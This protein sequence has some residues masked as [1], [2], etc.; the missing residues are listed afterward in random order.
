MTHFKAVQLSNLIICK[1]KTVFLSRILSLFC[2]C[3]FLTLHMFFSNKQPRRIT[4]ELWFLLRSALC[5]PGWDLLCG[6]EQALLPHPLSLPSPALQPPASPHSHSLE[7][8]CFVCVSASESSFAS[9][10]MKR[11]KQSKTNELCE[12]S[13]R[14]LNNRL[15]NGA[16]IASLM[17]VFI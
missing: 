17:G 11:K 9:V 6:T 14:L 8:F 7:P 2:Y 12:M 13:R 3:I 15:E 1:E 4:G 5:P 16:L 10:F